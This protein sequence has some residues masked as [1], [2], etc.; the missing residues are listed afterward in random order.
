MRLLFI[1]LAFIFISCSPSAKKDGSPVLGFVGF[2]TGSGAAYG[3]AQ[4]KGIELA[5]QESKTNLRLVVED[6]QGKKESA[7]HAVSRLINEEN[8]LIIIGPTLS[9]EMF[10]AGPVANDAET[11]IFGTSNTAEGIND[12][13]SYVFRNSLPESRAIPFALDAAVAKYSLKKIALMHSRNNDFAVSGYRIMKD[14]AIKKGLTITADESFSDGDVDYASQVTRIIASSP[15]AVL[16]SALYKEGSLALKKLREMGYRGVVV[17]GNGF[18]HPKFFEI[19]QSAS[20]GLI[21]AT[22]FSPESKNEKVQAFVKKFKEKYGHDPDQFAAQAYDATHIIM[23]AVNKSGNNRKALRDELASLKNYEGVSGKL[24][25][26]EKRNP[27]GEV[28]VVEAHNGKFIPL[29]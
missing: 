23:E 8:A 17:G 25:F 28:V 1:L 6:S 24:S 26:D 13:G 20:E 14:S 22:P 5:M 12:I 3:T 10:A 19:A 15:D 4:R 27:V 7:I 21:V 11:P 9:G 2:L 29:K 18:N 16:I